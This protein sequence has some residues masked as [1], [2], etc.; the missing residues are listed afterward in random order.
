MSQQCYCEPGY[1]ATFMGSVSTISIFNV[2]SFISPEIS[3]KIVVK[4]S[5]ELLCFSEFSLSMD[6]MEEKFSVLSSN[7]LFILTKC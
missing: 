6:E 4:E 3:L 7:E 2:S 1:V 5:D